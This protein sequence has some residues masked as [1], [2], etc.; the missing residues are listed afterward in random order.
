MYH[1]CD[2]LV[3][4]SVSRNEAFGV[5]Q[6]EAM[7]C[8][9]PVVSTNI[10]GSGVPWVNRHEET[11]LVVPAG[12]VAA[13]HGA[14]E[15]LLHDPALCASLGAQGRQRAMTEFTLERMV[16]RMLA[17]YQD[18]TSAATTSLAPLCSRVIVAD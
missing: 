3:L 11:G 4:P 6:I 18:V 1:A 10:Q 14:L 8:G 12:D 5:V 16:S 9:K 17:V 2:V 15:Q 13:L 7:M